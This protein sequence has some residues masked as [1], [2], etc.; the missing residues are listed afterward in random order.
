MRQAGLAS[1]CI[2]GIAGDE[3]AGSI[4]GENEICKTIDLKTGS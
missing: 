1:N 4:I 2:I 3:E